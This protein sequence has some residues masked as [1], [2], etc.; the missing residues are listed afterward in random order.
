MN[1]ALCEGLTNPQSCHGFSRT[2]SLS[3]H[4]DFRFV[5][6]YGRKFYCKISDSQKIGHISLSS[7]PLSL[8]LPFK[9]VAALTSSLKFLRFTREDSRKSSQIGF[10]ENG[11]AN[12]GLEGSGDEEIDSSMDDSQSVDMSSFIS[13]AVEG[14]SGGSRIG[15]IRSAE[16]LSRP[17]VHKFAKLSS[18]WK[19]E[20]VN[21]EASK[22]SEVET[23]EDLSE[24]SE[25]VPPSFGRDSCGACCSESGLN[26][27]SLQV[28]PHSQIARNKE[29]FARFLYRVTSAERERITQMAL[30][31]NLAYRIPTIEEDKLLSDHHFRVISSSFELKASA[32]PAGDVEDSVTE[33]VMTGIREGVIG[34][35]G[36]D[37]SSQMIDEGTLASLN[38]AAGYAMAATAASCN[39]QACDLLLSKSEST[40]SAIGEDVGGD[41]KNLPDKCDGVSGVLD[42]DMGDSNS[43]SKDPW[44]LRTASTVLRGARGV[45]GE[46]GKQTNTAV[47][48]PGCP[49]EWFA[50]KNEAL[51][52]L[53]IV[54]QVLSPQMTSLLQF[55]L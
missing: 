14:A 55:S 54:I 13:L 10:Q 34:L 52:T 19:K 15:M 26:D 28:T 33:E 23:A 36:I 24:S 46:Q 4:R 9:P 39:T 1:R 30:L 21:H 27:A 3:K 35:E 37:T 7:G 5:P 47:A 18:F 25:F 43:S 32:A 51:S 16:H 12:H 38:P 50:C 31:S 2:H 20:N 42:K 29:Y 44:Y 41:C 6:A 11:D 53:V 48:P 45:S 40:T 49:C 17:L 22:I 8:S